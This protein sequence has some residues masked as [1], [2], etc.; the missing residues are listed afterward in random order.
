[1]NDTGP[2]AAPRLTSP[3]LRQ[4]VARREIDSIDGVWHMSSVVVAPSVFWSS[5]AHS[6]LS[7]S[8]LFSLFECVM[9]KTG[10]DGLPVIEVPESG[11][12]TVIK[13]DLFER[14]ACPSG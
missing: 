2:L 14:E 5:Q 11:E 4:L 8:F 1:M 10:S 6:A 12:I 13:H 3:T 9:L 7:R